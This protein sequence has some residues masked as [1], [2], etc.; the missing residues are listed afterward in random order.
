MCALSLRP[1]TPDDVLD[2]IEDK[3][4]AFPHRADA[5]VI[6][7]GI[8]G[9]STAYYLAGAGLK[10]VVIEKDRVAGQQ[11][12]RNWGFV[13]TQYRD[14]AE[15]PLAVEALKLWRGLEAELGQPVGWRETG[16]LFAAADEAEFAA[17]QAWVR[18]VG[19]H[20][21]S[22]QLL[23]ATRTA[24]MLP[25]L[26][27]RSAGALYTP[28]DGQAE[29]GQATSAFARAAAARGVRVLEDC[30]AVAIDVAGGGVKGVLTEY[31]LITAGIVICAAGAVSH[32]L[33]RPLSLVLP[34][35]TVRNT[36]SLTTPVAPLSVP[37]FCGFGIGLRQRAD[38]SCIIAAE[39]MSD[40]DVTLGSFHNLRF[41]LSSF[42]ANRRSFRLSVGRALI[43]DLHALLVR[44]R[45]E[46]L[47]E[48]RRPFLPP[49]EK[50]AEEIRALLGRLF[51]GADKAGI[52]KSW[53]GAI[54]VLPDA[55]P[56]ID[57]D[58]GVAGLV[59]ATGF[60]GHGFGLGPA[61]GTNVAGLALGR[62]PAFDLKPFRLDRF[63]KGTFGQPHAPL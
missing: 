61:V 6:G 40:V 48:P 43:D 18:Q 63:A 58:T 27:R 28:D 7:G 20:A 37:C 36:V 53:A 39:S 42:L 19:D 38:G 49:N 1:H 51:T 23:D 60:S 13:R 24:E 17:F 31:G 34:Q 5:V 30:G 25:A 32:D 9:L 14:P 56:V 22:A 8:M 33:L 41:F 10:V 26:A 15:M 50:R 46:R 59:V 52:V 16:C 3:A 2:R 45:A 54:D 47:V 44:S 4:P 62:S 11:S 21:P 12:G 55:L 57:A 35:K 29:P